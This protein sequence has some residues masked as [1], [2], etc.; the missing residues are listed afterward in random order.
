LSGILPAVWHKTVI[1][2]D[3]LSPTRGSAYDDAWPMINRPGVYDG[4]A[5]YRI[6]PDKPLALIASD[7]ARQ[8]LGVVG[9]S[10]PGRSRSRR[11]S[12]AGPYIWVLIEFLGVEWRVRST[13]EWIDVAAAGAGKCGRRSR[14]KPRCGIPLEWAHSGYGAGKHGEIG[15]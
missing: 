14:D 2:V 4:G 15:R 7:R 5:C 6:Q 1:Q 3:G 10:S 11:L 9:G 13:A 8:W 12:L